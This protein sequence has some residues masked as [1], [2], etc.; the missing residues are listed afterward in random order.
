MSKTSL[1]Y[2]QS[3]KHFKHLKAARFPTKQSKPVSRWV[4]AIVRWMIAEDKRLNEGEKV[5]FS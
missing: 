5:S 2:K 4:Y 1:T 3:C